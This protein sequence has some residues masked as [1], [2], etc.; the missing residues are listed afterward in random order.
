MKTFKHKV[1]GEIAYYKDGVVKQGNCSIEIGREPSSEFWDEITKPLL[2]T[3]DGVA[4]FEGDTYYC[5]LG[6]YMVETKLG[7][8]GISEHSP[9]I[10]FAD[11]NKAEEFIKQNTITLTTKDGK[12]LKFGDTF[13]T[14]DTERFRVHEAVVGKTFQK[15]RWAENAFSTKEL[16][17]TWIRHNQKRYSLNDIKETV[18]KLGCSATVLIEYLENNG[19]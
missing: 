16:A 5:I 11:K 4:L 7:S 3:F 9:Y 6:N 2:K 1:T 14:V 10:R 17:E 12:T 15:D 8:Q 13:Y 19:R 18:N